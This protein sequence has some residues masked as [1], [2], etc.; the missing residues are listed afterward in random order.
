MLVS[1][2]DYAREETQYD[3]LIEGYV[4]LTTH[5]IRTALVQS[6]IPEEKGFRLLDFNNNLFMFILFFIWCNIKVEGMMIVW[7][8]RHIQGKKYVK[9]RNC[10]SHNQNQALITKTEKI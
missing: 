8:I 2:I 6:F 5:V 1:D 7:K 3:G 9:I 10:C 4:Y